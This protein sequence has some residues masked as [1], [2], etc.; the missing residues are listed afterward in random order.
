[1]SNHP[2][3]APAALAAVP[4]P[5]CAT[6]TVP[7]DVV[8]FN[9]NCEEMHQ[10]FLPLAGWPIYYHRC[11]ECGFVLAPE[12]QRWSE[13]D[14]LHHIYNEEYAA[15]DPDGAARR[16]AKD[17]AF[18]QQVFG[19]ARKQI[20]HLDYGGGA[21][22]LSAALVKHGWDSA[23]HEPFPRAGQQPAAPGKYNLITALKV[24][25]HVPDVQALLRA[26]TALMEDEALL[27]FSALLTDG[28]IKPNTRLTWWHAA[29]RNG[30]ISL[31]SRHSLMRLADQY[32][33]QFGSFNN[34]LHCLFNQL[35]AWAG[36]LLNPKAD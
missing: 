15:V 16:P 12:F 11:P 35:P 7:H 23:S 9:K 36:P 18:L 27:V 24:F 22:A 13:Q 10:R 33:L 4:C 3:S 21:G 32:G 25:E 29:P 20:R 30:H 6:Q 31:Y 5:V 34:G 19:S 8:D 17:A 14:F 28:N 26:L 1:M 2:I